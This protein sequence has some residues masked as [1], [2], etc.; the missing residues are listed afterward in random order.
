MVGGEMFSMEAHTGQL[1]KKGME[2]WLCWNFIIV[3]GVAQI[4]SKLWDKKSK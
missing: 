3:V 4:K 1:E 2:N